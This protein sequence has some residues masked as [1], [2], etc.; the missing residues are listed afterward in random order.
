MTKIIVDGFG[1]DHPDAV[2]RGVAKAIRAESEAY[3]LLSGQ[4]AYI[5]D[6]L[7]DEEF[8][9]SRLEI[10]DAEEVIT[11]NDHPSRAIVKK[12][13]S[14]LVVA[15]QR[16]KEDEECKA[17]ISAGNTGAVIAGGVLVLG[18]A[19]GVERP[20]LT[21]LLPT[22]NG[23]VSCMADCGANVD[24][25]PHQ[26]LSFAR[27][28][29][30]YMRRAYR[31]DN[32]KVGL[33]SVGT[34]DEKGNALTKETFGL[35]KESGLNFVGNIEAKTL[36]SGECDVIVTDGFAGNVAL[37]TIEGVSSTAIK[38][39]MGLLKKNAPKDVDF[40]FIMRSLGEFMS[41]YDF[42]SLGGAVLLGV[43]KP[44]VK[45]HGSSNEDTIVGAVRQALAAAQ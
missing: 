12:K 45:T 19:E 23:G 7:S 14:S 1:S 17:L 32:P 5:E 26:L 15:Y 3:I 8:D 18:R 41:I 21:T 27:L 22:A 37:K 43:Q 29:S 44:V 13:N 38:A 40:A 6:V 31:I 39:F 42:N 4:R 36:L 2:I 35:L 16:L 9:R 34:E 20:T 33:L 24:C 30:E 28:A 25:K 10:L 11:N